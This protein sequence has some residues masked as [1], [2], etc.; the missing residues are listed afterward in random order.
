MVEIP[1]VRIVR[2]ARVARQ[3]V[4][5]V[6]LLCFHCCDL[7]QVDLKK[8]GSQKYGPI[9]VEIIDSVDDYLKLMQEIFDFELMKSFFEKRPDF[10]VLMDSLSG[11]WLPLLTFVLIDTCPRLNFLLFFLCKVTGPYVTRILV[12][13]L[14]LP[15][16]SVVRNVPLPDFGGGHPDPNLTVRERFLGENARNSATER[17]LPH[18]THMSLLSRSTRKAVLLERLPT[19][20]ETA[21]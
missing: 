21:T 9:E 15:K 5:R 14:G 10:T 6:L 19:A 8:I 18:S 11:G 3:I 13:V 12:D 20:T 16:D 4:R 1:T 2:L 7:S 17:F